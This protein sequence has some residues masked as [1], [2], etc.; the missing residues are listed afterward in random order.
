M[1]RYLANEDGYTLVEL[2]VVIAILGVLIAIVVPN[3]T[4][5][6]SAGKQQA[7]E[8][9]RAI[10]QQTVDAYYALNIPN[11]YPVLQELPAPIHFISLTQG[12]QPLLRSVPRSQSPGGSYV[13]KID[14]N[15]R[16]FSD[17]PFNGSYP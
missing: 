4:G 12:T 11:R 17:P 7:Y 6:L 9:D 13:W 3:V 5:F 15:G 10:L 14:V 2:L 1:R 16:V 8:A